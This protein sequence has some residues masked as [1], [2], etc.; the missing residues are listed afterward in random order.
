MHAWKHEVN[1]GG[2]V[3]MPTVRKCTAMPPLPTPVV[4][5]SGV[6]TRQIWPDW[7]QDSSSP[8]RLRR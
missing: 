1:Q 2:T 7:T 6:H 8:P 5:R 4:L 3:W